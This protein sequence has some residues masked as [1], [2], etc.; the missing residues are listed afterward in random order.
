MVS[1]DEILLT[2]V[3]DFLLHIRFLMMVKTGAAKL[4]HQ[5]HYDQVVHAR[6]A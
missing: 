5:K 2:H 3:H 1:K 4:R 6:A